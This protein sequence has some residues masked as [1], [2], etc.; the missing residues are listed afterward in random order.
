M[1][2]Q[3]QRFVTLST[4]SSDQNHPKE[5][6]AQTAKR[7]FEEALQITEG[8]KRSEKQGRKGKIS[9][10]EC[11]VPENSDKKSFISFKLL[12]FIL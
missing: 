5:K 1:E 8:K 3:L 12:K 7:L 10:T 2:L 9:P 4:G 6:E 11:R